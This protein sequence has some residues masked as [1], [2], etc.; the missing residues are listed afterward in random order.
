VRK[1]DPSR[2][3]SGSNGSPQ[4]GQP[5]LLDQLREALRSRHSSRRIDQT[6]CPWVKR[7]TFFRATCHMLRHSFATH[8]LERDR[9]DD[10]PTMRTSPL[11]T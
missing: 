5:G 1:N 6:H 7:F 4:P 11:S 10:W 8:L 9:L 2:T 3:A